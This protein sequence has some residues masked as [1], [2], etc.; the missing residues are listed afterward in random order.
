[1]YDLFS[2]DREMKKRD[3]KQIILDEALNL[4]S[5][6]GYEGV[7]VADIADAVGI[8]AS[9][10]YKHYKNKQDI[11]DS[12]LTRMAGRYNEITNRLG[13]DGNDP[14]K[15]KTRYFN[16]DIDILVQ[17]GMNLFL[18]FLHDN[19]AKKFRRMLT[20]EQY[21]NPTASRLFVDQYIN[22]P[23]Q[24]QSAVFK[25]F[26]EQATMKNLDAKVAAMHFYAP[27]FLLL[28]L[29]DNCPDREQETLELIKQHIIQFSELYM[30]GRE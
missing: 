9:S 16:M 1:M 15:D 2:Q 4:F 3:T 29:C 27:I 7:T 14:E 12:I 24:Y 11:F 20:V 19:D 21:Q 23:I 17:T 30:R 25:A 10:L 5:V 6:S 26:M 18:Y 13:I 28:C 8:K 22:S